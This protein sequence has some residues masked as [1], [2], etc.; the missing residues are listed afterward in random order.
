MEDFAAHICPDFNRDLPSSSDVSLSCMSSAS[1]ICVTV[2]AADAPQRKPIHC[3][4]MLDVSG[5]MST[6]ATQDDPSSSSSG[7]SHASF[8]RLDL[9]KHSC[10]VV[11]EVMGDCDLLSVISFG[12]NSVLRLDKELMTS[13]GKWA[14]KFFFHNSILNNSILLEIHIIRR[15]ANRQANLRQSFYRRQHQPHRR[16]PL[17]ALSRASRPQQRKHSRA[18]SHRRRARRCL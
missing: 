16:Q 9:A 13:Q 18:D 10:K 6:S 1:H 17:G 5:S 11:V 12:S 15:Q 4:I 3:I 8:S 14:Q 2:A 7:E